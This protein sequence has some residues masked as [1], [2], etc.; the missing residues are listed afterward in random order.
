[1]IMQQPMQNTITI[2]KV[3]SRLEFLELNFSVFYSHFEDL[4]ISITV[5]KY[6]D[7]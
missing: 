2:F 3:P 5:K 1:M 6:S 7:W 4:F